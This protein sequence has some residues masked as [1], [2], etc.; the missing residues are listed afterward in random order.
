MTDQEK[1]H[2]LDSYPGNDEGQRELLNIAQ[3]Y[4]IYQHLKVEKSYLKLDKN[5]S[6]S[7]YDMNQPTDLNGYL[8]E[9]RRDN[10]HKL[11]L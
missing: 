4:N 6:D 5:E 8:G 2:L 9:V 11:K 10:K 1:D 7:D 3:L